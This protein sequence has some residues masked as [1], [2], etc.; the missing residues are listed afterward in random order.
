MTP[1]ARRGRPRGRSGGR[2]RC[3]A[4]LEPDRDVV[5]GGQHVAQ[6]APG[7]RDAPRLA[8]ADVARDDP[9]AVVRAFE[10]DQRRAR[11]RGGD[12]LAPQRAQRPAGRPV[13]EPVGGAAADRRDP[14]ARSRRS[15]STTCTLLGS[16]NVSGAAGG[17][18]GHHRG[19]RGAGRVDRAALDG[20]DV[21]ARPLREAL[22][23]ERRLP[24]R[25]GGSEDR[26]SARPGASA[27]AGTSSDTSIATSA[28]T[29]SSRSL[30]RSSEPDATR[31]RTIAR[32]IPASTE[33]EPDPQIGLHSDASGSLGHQ[34]EWS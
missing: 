5:P 17:R 12:D 32:T 3:S 22:I 33:S 24:A 2:A 27:V 23:G 21:L 4:L 16:V 7:P 31:D 20:E 30:T 34:E 25:G 11:H 19:P 14:V 10:R 26:A 1:R 15:Q 18:V 8:A 28:L 9:L 6:T 29:I 13:V